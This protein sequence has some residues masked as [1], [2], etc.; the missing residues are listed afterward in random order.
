MIRT[1]MMGEELVNSTTAT[2]GEATRTP[3]H[4]LTDGAAK[5]MI[6]I[7]TDATAKPPSSTPEMTT[8]VEAKA[9]TT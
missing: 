9:T 8:D 3:T 7:L 2:D 6:R 1:E 4:M 5:H